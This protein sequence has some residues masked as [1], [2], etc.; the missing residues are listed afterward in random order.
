VSPPPP[1]IGAEPTSR[2]RIA[3]SRG[4][5]GGRG[6]LP[7]AP[8]SAWQDW[9][10]PLAI[11][12]AA[13]TSPDAYLASVLRRLKSGS[14]AEDCDRNVQGLRPRSDCD[15]DGS[16]GSVRRCPAHPR[17]RKRRSNDACPSSRSCRGS[18]ELRRFSSRPALFDRRVRPFVNREARVVRISPCRTA[19]C[20][21]TIYRSVASPSQPPCRSSIHE[22]P[23][24]RMGWRRRA[25]SRMFILRSTSQA[26]ASRR[27]DRV[28]TFSAWVSRSARVRF[29]LGRAWTPDVRRSVR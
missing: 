14:G 26:M 7:T 24:S 8:Q 6:G 4:M 18:L 28:G 12:K 29:Q 13:T 1:S 15:D 21:Q 23:R 2:F 3:K 5:P 10:R 22:T 16:A 20:H 27:S 19:R 11:T 9:K 17:P 25:A